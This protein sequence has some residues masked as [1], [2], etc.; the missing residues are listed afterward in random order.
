MYVNRWGKTSKIDTV[1]LSGKKAMC[2][3]RWE[4]GLGGGTH[5]NPWLIHVNV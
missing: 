4:R 1:L 2:W 3:G 5:V